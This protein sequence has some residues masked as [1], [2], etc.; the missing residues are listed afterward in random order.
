MAKVYLET[1]FVSACVTARTDAGSVHRKRVSLEWWGTQR[2]RYELAVSDEVVTELSQ[3]SYP[4]REDALA[5]IGGIDSLAV[6]PEVTELARILID[7]R[8]MPAPLAGDAIHVAAAMFY[9]VEFVLS[10]NVRHLANPNKVRHLAT[11]CMRLRFVPPQI[12]T[13]DALWEPPDEPSR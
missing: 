2:H 13:P 1:S 5:F 12:V 6:T 10:W 4:Q 7:Q 11:I 8:V 9:H 3:P